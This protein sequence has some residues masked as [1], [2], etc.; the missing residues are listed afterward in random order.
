[1]TTRPMDDVQKD[2]ILTDCD[3]L[4]EALD[5]WVSKDIAMELASS[6]IGSMLSSDEQKEKFKRDEEERHRKRDEEHTIR[7][8]TSVQLQA[9]LYTLRD[10]LLVEQLV[11]Q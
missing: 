2:L 6:L 11:K 1:M 3:T 10:S 5:A 7:K 9:K 4:I 8:Q